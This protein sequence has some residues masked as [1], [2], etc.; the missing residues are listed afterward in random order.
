MKQFLTVLRYSFIRNCREPSTITEMVLLPLGLILVLGGA[1]GGAF[2]SRDIGPTPVAYVI[3]SDTPTARTVRDFLTRDDIARFLAPT[4]AGTL[5][6]ADELLASQEVF[7]VIHVPAG[8]GASP[9][10]AGI[11][12][13]E[14]TGN[15]L[16][17]GVVRA[18]LRNY[19]AAANVTAAL[20]V[21]APAS[22]APAD[23]G[24]PSVGYEPMRANFEAQEI[25]RAGRVPGAFDFY[26]I[27]MLVLFLMYVAGYSVDALR[28]DILEP[29]GLRVRTTAIPPWAHLSGRLSANT[30][31]GLVQATVI[32]VVTRLMFGANW[33]DRPLLIAAIVAAITLFAVSLGAVVLAIVRDG[34]KAQSIVNAIA[35]GSM[36]VS[37]GSIQF[38]AVGP[39]FRA[40][41]RLL[42]HYQGQ[43]ALL[44][45][46][47]DRAPAA[48]PEAFIYF[49][50][51]AV[52]ALVLTVLLVRRNA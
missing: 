5:E 39:G 46:V 23:A 28:E 34:Q 33:G 47:Y 24:T 20:L 13:I 36:I 44:A 6:R 52:I 17:T 32:V 31:S 14:R 11:R 22:S 16:R 1:L 19:V 10:A 27:S 26:S 15:Q 37:G 4:D 50:G 48:I 29:I 8:F 7:T 18:V 42:P 43:T 40:I 45:I 3:E 21:D 35:I 51:G 25:S 12:L 38:G 2:E 30:V 41:Q 9:D 49:I